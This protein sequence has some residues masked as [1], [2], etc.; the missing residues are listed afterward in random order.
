MYRGQSIT[1]RPFEADDLEKS[2]SWVNNPDIA[3]LVD[4]VLPVSKTEQEEWYEVI[5]SRTDCV[6][7]A[8]T[9]PIAD[10]HIG[11]VWLWDIHWRHRKCELRILIGDDCC[12]GKGFGTEA[13]QMAVLYAFEQL[14]LHRVYAY[15]LSNNPRA[16][17]AFEKAGF[18]REG[19]LKDA[20]FVE[21]DYLDGHVLARVRM[22]DCCDSQK[23]Q[24]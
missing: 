12:L 4:R 3:R 10:T 1:L 17:R 20:Y 22:S 11:N 18:A 23:E 9:E 5:R 8:I 6:F 24:H 2:R 14:N 15:V 13:I 16:L 19:L 7:F 21:G